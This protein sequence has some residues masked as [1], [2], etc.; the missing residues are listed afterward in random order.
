[1]TASDLH[2][3]LVQLREELAPEDEIEDARLAERGFRYTNQIS[4]ALFAVVAVAGIV[5]AQIRFTP[6]YDYERKRQ[7]PPDLTHA[8]ELSIDLTGASLRLRF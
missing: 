7:L 3:H 2:S 8:P 4:F 1:M 5:D 6:S